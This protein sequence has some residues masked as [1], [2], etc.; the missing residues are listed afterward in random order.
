MYQYLSK[1]NYLQH[2]SAASQKSFVQTF[3]RGYYDIEEELT[4]DIATCIASRQEGGNTI[5]TAKNTQGQL[6]LD[7]TDKKKVQLLHTAL[8]LP[9]QKQATDNAVYMALLILTLFIIRWHP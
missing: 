5:Y 9:A 4:T 6:A 8:L 3:E 2:Y 1:L 7:L